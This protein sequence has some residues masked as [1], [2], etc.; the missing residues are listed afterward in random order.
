[1][2]IEQLTLKLQETTDKASQN[3]TR[4]EKLEHES[5]VLHELATSVAVM[6]Q[7]L[8]TMSTNVTTLT[9][10]VGE[11]KDKPSKRWDSLINNII[12]AVVGAV[13]AFVLAKIGL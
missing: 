13:L 2:D 6:A 12:W 10:E 7:Q 5:E 11:L 3:E 4:I 9:N 8:K 1:M